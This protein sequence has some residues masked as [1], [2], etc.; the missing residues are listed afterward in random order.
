MHVVAIVDAAA[1]AVADAERLTAAL[2]DGLTP[3]ELRMALSAV[4]PSVLF[5][6]GSR[7]R[8]EQAAGILVAHGV[9]AMAVDLA[10]VPSLEQ[11]VHVRRFALEDTGLRSHTGGPLLAYDAMAAIVRVAIETSVWRTTRESERLVPGPRGERP[12]VTVERTRAEHT[13]EQ[14]LFLFERGGGMPWVL[15]ASDARYLGLGAALRPTTIE[16]FVATIAI[17]RERAPRAIYDDRFVAH[18]L[19]RQ[20]ETHVRGHDTAAP[21]LGDRA[22]EVRLHLLASTL[23]RGAH[24]GPYR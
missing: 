14:A 17:L 24:A 20:T 13:V 5:R 2:G 7:E 15:R 18:P 21:P 9:G 12:E 4:P 10:E 19:A 22:V 11:M 8:A 1:N 3:L 23:G 16:N 6:T